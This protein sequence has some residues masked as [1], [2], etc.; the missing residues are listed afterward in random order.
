MIVNGNFLFL[1]VEELQ[2]KADPNKKY[3]NISLLQGVDV[4]KVF[5]SPETVQK[6][7]G[8]KP[9]DRIKCDLKI[10]IS[11]PKTYIDITSVTKG[12]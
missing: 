3:F 5:G 9:M 11:G 8:I 1:G 7:T 4:L 10:S 2:A 6:F 12:V